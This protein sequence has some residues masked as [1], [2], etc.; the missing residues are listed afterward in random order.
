MGASVGDFY[1]GALFPGLVL[2]AA[3]AFWVF[4]VSIVKP[5]AAPACPPDAR[6]HYG[7]ALVL[8]VFTTMIPPLVLIFLVLGTIFIG[9]AT[10]TEG[11]AIG[12]SGAL[13][14]ALAKRK[15]TWRILREAL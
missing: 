15:L 13:A 3:Y 8:R 9:V 6:T 7:A 14:M 10:P 11:G 1:E 12:A 5:S 4:I 2:A